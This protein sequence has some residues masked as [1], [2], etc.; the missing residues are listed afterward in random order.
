MPS[1]LK[2]LSSTSVKAGSTYTQVADYR[3][4]NW[5][6][7]VGY[8]GSGRTNEPENS[9]TD[10]QRW[11]YQSPTERYAAYLW[12]YSAWGTVSDGINWVVAEGSSWYLH[13]YHP[14][15]KIFKYL[16]LRDEAS[17]LN[18]AKTKA[19]LKAGDMKSNFAVSIAEARKT[20]DLILST[21]TRIDRAYRALR[22]LD[23]REVS[24]QLD[25]SPE[26]VHKTWL[27]YRYGW[28]PLL[29][30]VKGSAELLAQ[31]H[32]GRAEDF[33]VN[34]TLRSE[35]TLARQIN[36]TGAG[37]W[38]SV[39]IA[40]GSCTV[41]VKLRCRIDNTAVAAFQ[42]MGLVNPALVAWELVPYSFVFD[43]FI[44]VGDWLTAVTALQGLQLISAMTSSVLE[45]DGSYTLWFTS[46]EAGGARHYGYPAGLKARKRIYSR[47]PLSL[48]G[49][50]VEPVVNEDPF[51]LKRVI[52]SLALLRSSSSR[53]VRI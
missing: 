52:T 3:S 1:D 5:T 11:A 33:V 44:S 46:Y 13:T 18:E 32:L 9:Y 49:L 41:R 2:D 39:A 17:M 26:Q 48:S 42:Q 28:L 22:R 14:E 16:I 23:F 27:E 38:G 35:N 31:H 53:T 34:A 43:W 29:M 51:N 10:Q 20:G 7:T 8:P 6:N 40:K 45:A 47:S 19:L 30:D 50:T 4:R 21:A 36:P 25:I 12:P 37:T 15:D 24:R